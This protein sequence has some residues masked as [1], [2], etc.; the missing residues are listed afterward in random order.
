MDENRLM[1][2]IG[3]IFGAFMVCFYLGIGFYLML[4]PNLI[5]SPNATSDKFLRFLVGSTFIVYGL[6]R[7]F[8]T[9]VKIREVFF[10]HDDEKK[11]NF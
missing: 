9:F 6:Y 3:T 11:R 1:Q 7:A 2:Q 5:L 4:S 8:R 10:T